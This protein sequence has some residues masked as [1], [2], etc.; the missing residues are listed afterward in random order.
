MGLTYTKLKSHIAGFKYQIDFDRPFP[1]QLI[2]WIQD[3]LDNRDYQVYRDAGLSIRKCILL[4][5]YKDV[6]IVLLRWS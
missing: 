2:N 6:V 1:Y 4:K 5:K 3:D